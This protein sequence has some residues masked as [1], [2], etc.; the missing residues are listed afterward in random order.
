VGLSHAIV[1]GVIAGVLNVLPFIGPT[2][3]VALIAAAAFLQF[4]AIEPA[5]A[6][7]GVAMAVAALEGNV[8]TPALTSRAGDINTVAVFVSVL[9][10]GW[11]WGIAGLVLAIPIVVAIKAAADHIEPLQPIGELLGL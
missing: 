3:G 7:G 5:L 1:W 9:F 4:K 6:A 2:V 11:M 10:W 8:I